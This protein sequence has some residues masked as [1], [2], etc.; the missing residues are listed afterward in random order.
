MKEKFTK[1]FDGLHLK[2]FKASE[3]LPYFE[4]SG[5]TIPPEELWKNCVETFRVLDALRDYFG[6]PVTITSSYRSPQYNKGVGGRPSSRHLRFNALDIQ[7]SGEEP[8]VVASKLKQWRS[9][10]VFKGGIGTY[11]TFVHLDT[12]GYNATW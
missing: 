7:V 12:R 1:F 6:R 3:L 9:A 2:N 10:G 4:R 11:N 5:N 8:A